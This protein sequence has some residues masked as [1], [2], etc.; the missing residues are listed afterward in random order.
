[1]S[2]KKLV[3]QIEA[4]IRKGKEIEA[5]LLESHKKLNEL[6]V[7]WAQAVDDP[8]KKFFSIVV[9]EG[10]KR[11]PLML[12]RRGIT[13]NETWRDADNGTSIVIERSKPVYFEE[14]GWEYNEL[15]RLYQ[16]LRN[17][18]DVIIKKGNS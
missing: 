5:K 8:K 3:S 18:K 6:L 2:I 17:Q 1:M 13:Y 9:N 10:T 14:D 12:E 4:Q 16:Y 15:R 7:K 11:K